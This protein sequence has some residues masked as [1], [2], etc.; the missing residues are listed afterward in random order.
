[1]NSFGAADI[2]RRLASRTPRPEASTQADIY[3]LLVT[4]D[5]GLDDEVVTE[6]P[7]EDGTRRRIDIDTGNLVIEVKKDLRK[8]GVLAEGREQLAGYMARRSRQ[9]GVPV[10]GV[11][12]DGSSWQLYRLTSDPESHQAESERVAEISIVESTDPA[13]ANRQSLMLLEWLESILATKPALAPTPEEIEKKLGASSPAH[14]LDFASLRDLYLDNSAD[15]EVKLKR[16]LWAKLLRTAFGASFVD[17]E[18]LFINHTLLVVTAEV[19]AHAAVGFDV[20]AH[21]G[22]SATQL[23]SGSLFT[24]RLIHG[25]VESDFFDWVVQVPGGDSL[26]EEVARRVARFDWAKV[27]NDVL[28]IL[29]ESVIPTSERE[30]LGEYYTPDWLADRVVADAVTYPLTQRVADPSCGS[31]TFLFHAVR[32]HLNAAESSG[33]ATG[34]AITSATRHVVGMDVHPVA[35]TLARVTYLLAIG[36]ERLQH[37]TRDEVVIPVYLGDSVQWEQHRDLLGG[38]DVIRVSTTGDDLV[39][40]GG[41]TLFAEDLV[42]PRAVLTD[43]S[44]FDRLVADMA[45]AAMDV[46]KSLDRTLIEPILNRH[47]VKDPVQRGTLT[48]TFSAMRALHR[49][50]RDH[51]WG[52]YV[53]NLIRPLWLADDEN[54]VD[55][56]VGNPPWLRYS[57]MTGSMQK[58][59]SALCKSRSLLGGRL[60]MSARDLS[61]LF[62]VRAVE[63]YLKPGGTFA[64]VMPH[65][66]LTRRPH[67]PFRSGQ[68][69][70]AAGDALTVR[71]SE[72]WDLA[73]ATTGFPMV[74]CVVRGLRSQTAKKMSASTL[75]YSGRLRRAD[76]PWSQAK[77]HLSIAPS[78]VAALSAVG[79]E[80]SPYA[81]RFRNGAILYP[82]LLLFVEES[83]AGMLGAGGGRTAVTSF[84]S[85]LEKDPWKSVPSLT[86][87][88]EKR[89][90]HPTLL[91]ENLLPFRIHAPRTAVLP[92]GEDAILNESEIAQFTGLASWWAKAEAEWASHRKKSEKSAL[93]NRIDYHGQLSAQVP[94]PATRLVYAASGNTLP[95]SLLTDP[96]AIIEHKLYWA[97]VATV[98]EGHYLCAIINS[99]TLLERVKPLQALGLFGGRD[100]DKNIF[101]VPFPLFDH[102]DEVHLRLSALGERAAEFAADVDV[103][104]GRTFQA[105]R[106]LVAAAL[107][108]SGISAE[109]D[110]AVAELVPDDFLD[111]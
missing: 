21:G 11:L 83:D 84:R 51:I 95:A 103:S 20:S 101:S 102:S 44:R 70:D 71:F 38:V 42:F 2:V 18:D 5:L 26:V 31:G 19:I 10:A 8:T 52:Y 4:E 40:E 48:Q 81:A 100:W 63:L 78:T 59:Y 39:D 87:M 22:L 53:R 61:T 76:S 92:L 12:T 54:R 96:D 74:S 94:I 93:L 14:L 98:A 64:F 23:T 35:V 7:T 30:R 36:L 15:P 82:R 65:G 3:T 34:E 110:A 50:G 29:Y 89:F 88:V 85:T 47:K 86:G 57:K 55:V 9:K 49:S 27:E 24:E 58:R 107:A 45:S 109:I 33:M 6:S 69:T 17:D 41:G 77:D 73:Q 62:V 37:E 28:K 97:P 79:P 67:E 108:E 13:E 75:A 25:V 66:T 99:A 111:T 60:G 43:A 68:W 1:M 90:L 46:S 104:P 72:S 106:K 32:A 80:P 91:G 56:L 16:Q 105:R